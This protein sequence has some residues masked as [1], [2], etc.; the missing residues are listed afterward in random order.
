MKW[1]NAV[2]P[3]PG[4]LQIKISAGNEHML[5]FNFLAVSDYNIAAP[6]LQMH[7]FMTFPTITADTSWRCRLR[8]GMNISV[9]P[10]IEY[11]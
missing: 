9:V 8:C 4:T 2:P 11:F 1:I 10:F 7:K 5:Q 3:T 6:I